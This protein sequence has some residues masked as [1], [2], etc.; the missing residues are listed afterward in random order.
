M[1]FGLDR[2]RRHSAGLKIEIE[3]GIVQS[4]VAEELPDEFK[5]AGC[6]ELVDEKSVMFERIGHGTAGTPDTVLGSVDQFRM[7]IQG[8]GSSGEPF[9]QWICPKSLPQPQSIKYA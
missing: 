8:Y 1:F 2:N 4:S 3:F 6:D 7:F 9:P 5:N